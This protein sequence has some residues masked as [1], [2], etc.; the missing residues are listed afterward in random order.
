VHGLQLLQ[1][2]SVA[3]VTYGHINMANLQIELEWYRYSKGYRLVEGGS[4]PMLEG[5]R[6]VE[7]YDD[8]IVPNGGNRIPCP[9]FEKLD[10]LYIAFSR[11]RTP[12]DLLQ[13]I[14]IHGLLG[15]PPEETVSSR[16]RGSAEGDSVPRC[17]KSAEEFRELLSHNRKS[18][19]ELASF[20][21]GLLAKK[22]LARRKELNK[23]FL[24]LQLPFPGH[25]QEK[26]A[27]RISDLDVPPSPFQ[28]VG[29][30]ELVPDPS[31]GVRL[32]IRSQS[33]IAALWWQLSREVSYGA[34]IRECRH[35][36]DCFEAGIGTGRRADAQFCTEE[37]KKR[38]FSL[39]R[40]RG[41]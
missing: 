22:D 28:F 19:R 31:R 7:R 26:L 29:L 27:R 13:F 33:L 3:S 40:S 24:A 41:E 38:F 39:E 5:F 4:R 6:L 34:N 36:G 30:I 20:F 35:C 25:K 21:D 23:L 12:A 32:R 11:V 1:L 15:L 14:E 18:P 9:P 16:A 17:L 2:F 10:R 8:M 37:H